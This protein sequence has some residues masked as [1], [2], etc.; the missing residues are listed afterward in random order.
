MF[1]V[2]RSRLPSNQGFTLVELLT[3]V[4]IIGVLIALLL[5]AVQA[6]REAARRTNCLNNVKQIALATLNFESSQQHFPPGKHGPQMPLLAHRSWFCELLPY[7]EQDAIYQQ[8]NREFESPGFFRSFSSHKGMQTVMPA[9]ACQ[10]QP[11]SDQLHFTHHGILVANTSYLGVSGTNWETTDGV[12]FLDSA[13]RLADITDGASHTLLVGERPP[14]PDFWYGWWYAGVGQQYTGS[15]D[16]LLGARETKAPKIVGQG[17][18]L[19]AC[20]NGPYHF[21]AGSSG[22]MCDTFHFWSYHP[23]GAVFGKCDGSVEFLN[24]S[25]DTILPSLATRSSGEVE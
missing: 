10:S 17:D 4:G 15:L 22:E 9:F 24:Y 21:Q 12:L 25:A 5:P 13:I 6:V 1:H 20:P 14:S 11:E 3:V 23:G 7:L 18:Y 8:S 2:H 16:M 19:D